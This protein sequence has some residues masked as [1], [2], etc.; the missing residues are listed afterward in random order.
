[1]K[2]FDGMRITAEVLKDVTAGCEALG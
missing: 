1:M 2:E